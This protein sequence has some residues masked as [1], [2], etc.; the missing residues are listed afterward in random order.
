MQESFQDPETTRKSATSITTI[1][2]ASVVLLAVVAGVWF[3][4]EPFTAH[5]RPSGPAVAN[6]KMTPAEQE[7]VKNI[8]IGNV[9]LSRAENFLHQEVTILNG[10]VYNAGPASLSSLRLTTTFSDEMNQIALRETRSI[11][12]SPEVSLAPGERRSF[13]ISFD[14]VP[15]SWNMQ[16]PTIIVAYLQFSSR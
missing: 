16:Q 3:I 6:L 15:N 11:L 5:K 12:G 9:S 8:Q 7:Y 14:H 13:E 10:E 2:I 4:F 1:I